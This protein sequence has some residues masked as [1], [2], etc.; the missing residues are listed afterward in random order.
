MVDITMALAKGHPRTELLDG[1]L[2]PPMP[3]KR[4]G[5]R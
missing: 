4:Q 1:H 2:E 5:A 3:A